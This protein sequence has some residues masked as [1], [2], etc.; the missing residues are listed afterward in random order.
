MLDCLVQK[1]LPVH[2]DP[3]V[4]KDRLCVAIES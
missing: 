4:R 1:D 2:K 3:Q